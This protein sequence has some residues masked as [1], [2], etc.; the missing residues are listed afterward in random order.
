MQ[1]NSHI[2]E[3]LKF[4]TELRTNNNREWFTAHKQHYEA[5]RASWL[6]DLQQLITIMS[7]YDQSLCNIQAKDCAYRIYRDIRFSPDKTPYK[8]HFGA[9]LG[10]K[11]RRTQK[12]CYYIHLEPGASGLYAGLWCPESSIL[13]AVRSLIDAESQEFSALL[14]DNGFASH[15]T[16]MPIHTLKKVPAGYDADHPLATILKAKDYTFGRNVP[17]SYFT[18]GNWTERVAEDF[19]YFKPMNDFLNYVFE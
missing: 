5:L 4:L 6:N 8:T 11:G 19:E 9:V 18:T 13:R 1:Q 3:I 2:S 10:E 15:F 17:D 14:N 7:S 16:F 12:S